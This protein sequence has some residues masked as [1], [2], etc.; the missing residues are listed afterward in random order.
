[1][2][3]NKNQK[4]YIYLF[5]VFSLIISF[6][7]GENSSGGS[8]LDYQITRG[9]IDDFSINFNKG[10]K[11]F[12]GPGQVQSPIFYI[13]ISFFEKIVG[14]NHLK[15]LYILVSSSIPLFL[16]IS[17][18]KKFQNKNKNYLF[19]LSLIIF[20]SPY[21]RSSA[22][23]MTN[24][25]MGILF[26]ILSA[27]K[28]LSLEKRSNLT[29][30]LLCV[31]Y[32]AIATYIR[33]YYCIFFIFY[34]FRF[35]EILNI[36]KIFFIIIYLAIIFIPFL[37][38]YYYFFISN[39]SLFLSSQ[40]DDKHFEL[41]IIKS[42][43]IFLSLYFFYT[44]PFYIIKLNKFYKNFKEN[45]FK[46]LLLFFTFVI[47]YFISSKN[48]SIY[49]GGIFMKISL[50]SNIYEIFFLTSFFGALLLS[51]NININNFIIYLCLI[52]AFPTIL[53][54]QKYY[55]P[56]LI[57]TL[58]TLTKEGIINKFITKQEININYLYLYFFIFLISSNIY[59]LKT[60]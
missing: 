35:I 34:F 12:I 38:Y 53:I 30:A 29:N 7:L 50:I 41:N 21:F 4:I 22:V 10:I 20:L 42:S 32:L 43:L 39:T 14:N 8:K 36:K 31:T 44:A 5:C 18:K 37:I 52:F 45:L 58:F 47:I 24:D 13:L 40:S 17:L 3:I 15:Y 25:N 56:L 6:Y 46:Y 49:G 23:W 51:L 28:Y 19:F 9:I 16:Y 55:D 59:Y 2:F 57:L 33:Q 60:V 1:M 11:N 27:S 54:Y 26:F 48:M